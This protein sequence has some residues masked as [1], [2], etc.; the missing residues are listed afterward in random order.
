MKTISVCL[1]NKNHPGNHIFISPKKE[2]LKW[3]KQNNINM[4]FSL[5]RDT[6]DWK[7]GPWHT[8]HRFGLLLYVVGLVQY[9]FSGSVCCHKW[10]WQQW[11]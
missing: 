3:L 11:K 8:V 4:C 6:T 2:T 5:L 7:Y 10:F 9:R 1:L